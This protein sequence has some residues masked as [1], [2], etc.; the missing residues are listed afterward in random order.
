MENVISNEVLP[1]SSDL[2]MILTL[3]NTVLESEYR[4]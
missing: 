3:S 4:E 2:L 1:A